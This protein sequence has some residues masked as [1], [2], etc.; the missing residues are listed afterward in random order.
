MPSVRC[1]VCEAVFLTKDPKRILC[2][3]CAEDTRDDIV[4]QVSKHQEAARKAM[5]PPATPQTVDP[6]TGKRRTRKATK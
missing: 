5:A 3:R 6:R 4:E 2:H 1:S